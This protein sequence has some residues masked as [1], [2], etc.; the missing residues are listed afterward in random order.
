MYTG[1]SGNRIQF[2]L[3]ASAISLA[4]P[5]L[6]VG[7]AQA[8]T[9]TRLSSD[10]RDLRDAFAPDLKQVKTPQEFADYLRTHQSLRQRYARHF[11][12]SQ[13]K[14]VDFFRNAVV[15]TTLK[16]SQRLMTFGV[17]K[18]GSIYAVR[19]KLP[20]GT[21]VWATREGV[22]V[23]KWNCANPLSKTL[24]GSDLDQPLAYSTA[25]SNVRMAE[26]D[27]SYLSIDTEDI[28]DIP[29]G[30]IVAIEP[31]VTPLDETIASSSLPIGEIITEGARRRPDLWPLLLLPLGVAVST[32]H[33]GSDSPIPPILTG[34]TPPEQPMPPIL[35][36]ETPPYGGV[37]VPPAIPEMNSGIL[38]GVGISLLAGGLFL[39]RRQRMA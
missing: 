31:P 2:L 15:P 34:E 5:A 24:P 28:A 4:I 22:P 39:V 6:G 9:T 38:C 36:G 16:K 19:T 11:N 3:L 27:S 8:Q 13:D 37:V 21:P 35:T 26:G 14:I 17:T 7:T 25:P 33:P 32:H 18:S 29:P 30:D 1:R 20:A 10:P 23:V 12:V